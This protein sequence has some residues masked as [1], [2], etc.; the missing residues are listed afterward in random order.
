MWP[1]CSTS[2]SR[3]HDE[4]EEGGHACVKS[5]Y[6]KGKASWVVKVA[7]GFPGNAALG[8]LQLSRMHAPLQP[9]HG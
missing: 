2:T 4:D 8:L 9:D 6:I 1:T 7:G 5:G 3:P